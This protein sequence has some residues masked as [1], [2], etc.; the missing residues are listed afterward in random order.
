MLVFII[1]GIGD[2]TSYIQ[3]RTDDWNS[4]FGLEPIVL[5]FGWRG[6]YKKNYEKLMQL[7]IKRAGREQ[8]ALV[9]ISAGASIAI[10]LSAELANEINAVTICGRTTRG[11]F[12]LTRFKP[13][14]AYWESVD[15][16]ISSNTNSKILVIKPLFDE[17]VSTKHMDYKDAQTLTVPY[18]FHIPSIFLILSRQSDKI[19]M[20]INDNTR[21]VK[22]S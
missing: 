17:I 19:A 9:G 12:Q 1:A 2:H 10:R 21:K 16:L 13:H 5:N 6:D 18:L 14:P 8:F 3:K 11:G 7:I 20:F 4:K 15:Q 22:S